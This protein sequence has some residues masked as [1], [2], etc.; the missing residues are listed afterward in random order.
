MSL[1]DRLATGKKPQQ[2]IPFARRLSH[3]LLRLLP[4]STPSVRPWAPRAGRSRL[5]PRPSATS[6][7]SLAPT[8]AASGRYGG[9]FLMMVMCC[10]LLAIAVTATASRPNDETDGRRD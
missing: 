7:S 2:A 5:R 10:D 1:D 3:Y 8:T 4:T 6:P 9:W